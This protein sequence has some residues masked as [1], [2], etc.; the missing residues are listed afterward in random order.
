[1]VDTLGMLHEGE[2]G[3]EQLSSPPRWGSAY[4]LTWFFTVLHSTQCI[5]AAHVLTS[6]SGMNCSEGGFQESLGARGPQIPGALCFHCR[7][8]GSVSSWGTKTQRA[9]WPKKGK[10]L[11]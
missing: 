6:L 9:A 7:D 4:P 1:M 5:I 8:P 10:N 2:L 3:S 11:Y